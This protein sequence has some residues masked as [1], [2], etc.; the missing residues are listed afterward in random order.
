VLL[1]EFTTSDRKSDF[2]R[3]LAAFLVGGLLGSAPL[4]ISNHAITG[5][6]LSFGYSYGANA[7]FSLQNIPAGLMYL[8]AT[9]ASVL[10]AIFGWG[11]GIVSGWPILSLSLA[12]AFVPFLLR[13]FGRFDLLLAGFL[14]TLPLSFL[15][16]GF[17]GLHGYGA[18][19]YFEAFV[20]LYLLT[21]RGLVLLAGLDADRPVRFVQGRAIGAA[22]IALFALLTFSTVSTLRPRLSQYRG[23]NWVDGSL[24]RTIERQGVRKALILFSNTDWFP[25]GAASRLL[26]ADLD[27]DLVFGVSRPDNSRILAF[28]SD[29]PAYVWSGAALSLAA[30]PASDR[31]RSPLPPR[32]SGERV[33]PM[34]AYWIGFWALGVG[35]I[36]L[37]ARGSTPR[38]RGRA[39]PS[40][41]VAQAPRLAVSTARSPV[42]RSVEPILRAP[43]R[44]RPPVDEKKRPESVRPIRAAAGIF[45]AYV[46]QTLILADGLSLRLVSFG[47][48]ARALFHAGWLLLLVGAIVFG[49]AWPA[50]APDSSAGDLKEADP[51]AGEERRS[52]P[53]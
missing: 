29:R 27:A 11:W 9:A 20:G 21:S 8:D 14:V 44:Q 37:L 1:R 32:S 52:H 48:S 7:G 36:R 43:K 26:P 51:R 39:A 45:F 17:H 15:A 23:Y 49:A 47:L 12:F 22:G 18:R 30:R 40:A 24:E 35:G 28:Y 2:L 5:D 10:P 4:F 33:T 41:P 38:D 19:F 46:G 16:W 50:S 13:R 3:L 53:E 34:L 6:F 42:A 31:F 25:W